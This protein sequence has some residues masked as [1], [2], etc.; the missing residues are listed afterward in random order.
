[1]AREE[2]DRNRKGNRGNE[3]TIKVWMERKWETPLRENQEC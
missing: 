2:G 3:E 1:M